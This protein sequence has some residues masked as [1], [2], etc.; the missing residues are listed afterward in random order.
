MG[1]EGSESD[2]G[3]DRP[4]VVVPRSG[5]SS[6]PRS[7]G[8]RY[9]DGGVTVIERPGRSRSRSPSR[10][11]YLGDGS[12]GRSPGRASTRTPIILGDRPTSSRRSSRPH[13]VIPEQDYRSD[14]EPPTYIVPRSPRSPSGREG[15]IIVGGPSSRH[16]RSR[17]SSV[18]LQQDEPYDDVDDRPSV[19]YAPPRSSR[20]SSRAPSIIHSRGPSRLSQRP[21]TVVVPQDDYDDESPEPVYVPRPS[22]ARGSRPPSVIYENRPRSG[23][24]RGSII[25]Q[26][27][28]ESDR[29]RDR[30][31]TVVY[32][33]PPRT[34]SPTRSIISRSSR[35]GDPYVQDPYD[36][37]D[38]GR[39]PTVVYAPPPLRSESPARS[40]ISRSSRRPSTRAS[41]RPVDI[42]APRDEYSP[43]RERPPLV[44][45]TRTPSPQP[46]GYADAPYE[47]SRA[48]SRARSSRPLS[49]R[50]GGSYRPD[51][52]VSRRSHTPVDDDYI[53]PRSIVPLSPEDEDD[54]AAPV[55]STRGSAYGDDG[56]RSRSRTP[57]QTYVGQPE[58]VTAR[59]FAEP[60]G[61]LTRPPS[62]F[63]DE[64]DFPERH[65]I[66]GGEESPPPLTPRSFRDYGD[67]RDR[68]VVTPRRSRP[69]SMADAPIRHPPV[70]CCLLFS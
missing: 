9:D 15:P 17:P 42:V 19:V 64:G 57:R 43:E 35:R 13:V 53:P 47:P 49:I 29:D 24:R 44:F 8:S 34:A 4:I 3:G 5:R 46:I 45:P 65:S 66:R 1:D 40:M 52:A 60:R 25:V 12:R 26:D 7:R 61:R 41:R 62:A 11:I 22:S 2:S 32:A 38:R 51:D 20:R 18:I 48:P 33:A 30:E 10:P 70:S 27:P 39:D 58:P 37:R 23:S 36:E 59:D 28:Y 14:E 6:R 68:A 56:R 16:S 69:P 21:Q 67:P 63:G 50:S 31:P 54:G 55:R